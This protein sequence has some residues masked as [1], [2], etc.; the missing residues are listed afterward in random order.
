MVATSTTSQLL[1]RN[2][3]G[4]Q[5]LDPDEI[6]RTI[7]RLIHRIDERFQDRGLAVACRRLHEIAV[8]AKERAEWIARPI[9]S[10]RIG[11]AL[12]IA[13]I[14]ASVIWMFMAVRGDVGD[15][16][17]VE[18]IQVL[19]AGINDVVLLG[20]A[21]FFLATLETR[22]KRR[23]ALDAVHELRAV[24]H[25]ID[26]LQL[27]KDPERITH[28][29]TRTP[30][31]PEIHMTAFELSRYLDYCA[32]MLSLTGKVAALYVQDFDD[33]VAIASVNEV[34]DLTS[35]LSTKIWQKLMMLHAGR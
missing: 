33:G 21:I 7:D 1:K 19:E 18:L 16:D 12:I 28:P 31:S 26:M 13:F 9:V 11:V 27:T 2:P 35:G 4:Y 8:N 30:S 24:A 3:R 17:T 14:V 20:A 5:A 6:T 29:E 15:L 25:I 32:E 23:R 34:E 10:V 22:V